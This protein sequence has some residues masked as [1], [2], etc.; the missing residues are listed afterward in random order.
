MSEE[1]VDVLSTKTVS[2][3]GAPRGNT[4]A[5]R[6][7]LSVLRRAVNR[8]GNRLIDRRTVIGKALLK[9]RQDLISDLG[10]DIS[11]QQSALVDLCVKSKLMLDSIDVWLLTQGSLINKRKKSLIPVVI[12][13]QHLADGLARY[14]SMLGLERKVRVKTLDQILSEDEEDHEP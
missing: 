12:Q 4:N 13:R 6:H 5:R 7:G 3:G 1:P 14:L 2:R 11:T 10:G 8:I 9:W